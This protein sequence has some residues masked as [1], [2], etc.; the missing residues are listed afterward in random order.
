MHRI[1]VLSQQNDSVTENLVAFFS[2]KIIAKRRELL[3]QEKECLAA[4][5]SVYK[6]FTCTCLERCL[7]FRQTIIVKSA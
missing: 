7:I 3:S 1:G 6:L 4:I 2:K 5:N